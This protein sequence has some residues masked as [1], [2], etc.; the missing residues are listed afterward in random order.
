MPVISVITPVHPAAAGF[1]DETYHCLAGQRLPAGWSLQWLVQADG[2]VDLKHL[3]DEP[4][5]S[6][7]TGR[8]G[9]AARARTLALARARGVLLRQLDAD[10][11]LPDPLTLARD[12][13]TLIDNPTIAW[14]V[15]PCLDLRADG[16]TALGPYDPAPGLLP[17]RTLL[18]GLLAERLPVMGTTITLYTEL[19]RALGAWPALPYGQDVALSLNAEAVSAGWMQEQPG[20]LY[21]Q[22]PGQAT[23][24]RPAGER[25]IARKVLA[26]QAQALHRTDWA[27]RPPAEVL[28]EGPGHPKAP[29]LA[30]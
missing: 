17:P 12:I 22:H 3:P 24:F 14:V 16:S 1:V 27:Y 8:P 18:D 2:P 28:R 13:H 30:S 5:I 20:E 23:L 29:P 15:S 26:D 10:D 9:G 4:W 25:R 19:A 21:R 11:L 6:T 7:G